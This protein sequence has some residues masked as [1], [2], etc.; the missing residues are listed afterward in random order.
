MLSTIRD[1]R[2]VSSTPHQFRIGSRRYRMADIPGYMDRQACDTQF[3]FETPNTRAASDS[4]TL[5]NRAYLAATRA[6]FACHLP[7]ARSDKSLVRSIRSAT[8]AEVMGI[9]LSN[10]CVFGA[11]GMSAGMYP[12]REGSARESC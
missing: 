4:V 2:R 3:R 10:G 12:A 5:A 9:G 6:S 7:D 1:D 8:S 11:C